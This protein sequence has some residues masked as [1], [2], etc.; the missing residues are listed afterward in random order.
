MYL[1]L[2]IILECRL[3]IVKFYQSMLS[4]YTFNKNYFFHILY[5]RYFYTHTIYNIL[6]M[7]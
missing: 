2:D 1:K 7:I 4:L 3:I 5:M 6:Y